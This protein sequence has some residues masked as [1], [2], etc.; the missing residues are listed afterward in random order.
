MKGLIYKE[1]FLGKKSYISFMGIAAGL[2]L[3]GIL[4]G[5]ST[6]WGNLHEPVQEGSDEIVSYFQAFVYFTYAVLL[7]MFSEGLFSV[8]RDRSCHWNILEY[9]MPVSAGKQMAVRYL[10][11][12]IVMG[13]GFLIGL[14]NACLMGLLFGQSITGVMMKNLLIMFLVALLVFWVGMPFFQSFSFLAIVNTLSIITIV[15]GIVFS[16]RIIKEPEVINI[17]MDD[18]IIRSFDTFFYLSPI[19]MP[20][21]LAVSFTLSVKFYQRREK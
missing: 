8:H 13:C 5:A 9:T 17:F 14:V 1:L 19:V 21:V 12:A 2:M 16:I 10:T 20:L 7:C 4:V 11:N 18:R 15:G 6:R 3:L